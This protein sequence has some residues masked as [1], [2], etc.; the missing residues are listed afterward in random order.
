M[1]THHA[2]VRFRHAGAAAVA[3]AAGSKVRLRH[4]AASA[5]P[6][7]A[8]TRFLHCTW[9]L[10]AGAAA[11]PSVLARS[12]TRSL[13]DNC[14]TAGACGPPVGGFLLRRVSFCQAA[15]IAAPNFGLYA[16]DPFMCA[17]PNDRPLLSLAMRLMCPFSPQR[18]KSSSFLAH[19]VLGPVDIIRKGL[20]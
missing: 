9:P 3:A 16:C 11:E 4:A 1:K 5:G 6:P 20:R 2:A 17:V 14:W 15:T 18:Q 7:T 12:E 19:V 10:L 8:P 13:H